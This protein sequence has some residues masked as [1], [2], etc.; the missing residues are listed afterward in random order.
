ML[1][2]QV[3]EEVVLVNASALVANHVLVALLEAAKR[4]VSDYRD[5]LL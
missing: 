1:I 4:G 3:V 5:T 2:S